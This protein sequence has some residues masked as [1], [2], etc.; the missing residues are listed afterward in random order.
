[1]ISK[2]EGSIYAPIALVAEA[3]GHWEEVYERPFV[4]PS[5]QDKLLPWWRACSPVLDRSM[6]YITNTWDQGQPANIRTISEADMRASMQRLHERLAKLE[7]PEGNGPRVIVA[8]GNYALYALTGNGVISFHSHDGRHKRP[9]I[10]DWRGSILTYTD[11][12]GRK[13]K[14]IPSPHPAMTFRK[15]EWDWVCQMD[16]QRIAEE[17]QFSEL[18]M[19]Q[20]TNLIA[21]SIPELREWIHWTRGEAEKRKGGE[22]YF[23]RLACSADVETPF[24][25]EYEW[26]Q[27]A[28][29]SEAATL[30]CR[31]CGHARR[32][33]E[34][35]CVKKGLKKDGAI[36]CGCTKFAPP[37]G[38][39]RKV[40]VREDAYLGCIGWAWNPALS[41]TAPTTLEFWQDPVVFAQAMAL[42]RDFHADPN[43]DFGGQNF[44]FDCWWAAEE[45]VPFKNQAWDLM[46]MH[47]VKRPWSTW[48]D[49]AF[50]ASVDIKLPF[51]KHESKLP[52][53]ISRWSHNK[54][55][56]WRYNGTDNCGQIELLPVH[57]K[58]LIDAGRLAYYEEIEAPIDAALLELS[59]WGMR[60]DEEGRQ[61]HFDTCIAEAKQIGAEINT[62]AEM[63]I[64]K[65]IA[66]S[67]KQLKEFLYEKL[68]LPLQ[69]KKTK[70]DGQTKKSI[71]TDI[72]TIKRLMEQ[73]PGLEQL[74]VV[75]KKVLRHRRV[76]VEA[77]FVKASAVDADGRIRAIFKQ[78][79]LLGRL[80]SSKTPKK[81]GRNLQNIDR[82]L[83]RFFLADAGDEKEPEC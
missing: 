64:V 12:R 11:L 51:W 5:Y 73:F 37:L 2:D 52:E 27:K 28:S 68:R 31:G 4:G 67:V 48:H 74:Q 54:E 66:P 49:L 59:R 18:R 39:P 76:G 82:R 57:V 63:P 36:V 8:A 25:T 3:Y 20:R 23:G 50:Q 70:K 42:I 77:N 69:Y 44:G 13:I 55:Q 60:A 79:T 72:V 22:K 62:A 24:K 1:M 81:K 7:G 47:R 61:K 15:P 14:V 78:D 83:R 53:E 41:M 33:H 65:K 58:G 38:K 43:I 35:A 19:L 10:L 21:P 9:G 40:K 56:L 16:W 30:K 45:N 17:A 75:G 6:F 71:S 26:R 29:E 34:D 32:W 46:K 80:S